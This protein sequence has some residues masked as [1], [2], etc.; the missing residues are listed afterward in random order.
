M[1]DKLIAILLRAESNGYGYEECCQIGIVSQE[2]FDTEFPH[3][4]M[5]NPMAKLL[6][7]DIRII[8]QVMTV[9]KNL[10]GFKYYTII[11][12]NGRE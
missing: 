6:S 4:Y 9:Y 3:I 11:V 12:V 5:P 8:D 2:S 7:D 10:L 1:P